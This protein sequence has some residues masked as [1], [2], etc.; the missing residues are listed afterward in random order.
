MAIRRIE[1]PIFGKDGVESL[2]N[3]ASIVAS[4]FEAQ[5]EV[6]FIRPAAS[7][8]ALYDAG[9]GFASA[10][11]IDQIEQEGEAAAEAAHR[12]YQEWRKG[13]TGL[14]RIEWYVEEGHTG[15]VIAQR[16]CLADVILLQRAGEKDAS[17]DEPFE[18]AVFGAGK[19]AMV[20]DK[21]LPANFLDHVFIAWNES[22]ESARAIAQ[23]LP[24]LAKAG[25]VSIFTA[26]EAGG[27]AGDAQDLV[28][29]LSLH[30]VAATPVSV[31][32]AGTVAESLVQTLRKQGATLLVMGAY[33]HGRVRQMLFGGVTQHVLTTPGVPA[34]FA[35]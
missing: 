13:R 12:S 34:L 28:S 2:L 29:Y 24:F 17:I 31:E 14:P 7:D 21:V 23:S 19:L 33:T 30:G 5:V 4:R 8:A 18:A 35:H 10:S 26:A 9:F 6:R 20:V 15:S 11:L 27:V 1:V 22:T 32:N 16:G 25:R 3:A